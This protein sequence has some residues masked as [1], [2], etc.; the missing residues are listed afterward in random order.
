MAHQ[1]KR[2]P[3]IELADV[4]ELHK[5]YAVVEHVQ[6]EM[7]S[8]EDL[9]EEYKLPEGF[10]SLIIPGVPGPGKP[11]SKAILGSKLKVV[12]RGHLPGDVVLLCRNP[13][14]IGMVYN[15]H[16]TVDLR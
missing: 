3:D 10:V 11:L 16:S 5:T 13:D 8:D 6:W 7:S 1:L 14:R 2:N 15:I 12:D 9:D 4:V